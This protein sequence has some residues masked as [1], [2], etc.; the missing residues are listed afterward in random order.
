VAGRVG[1]KAANVE[2]FTANH[3]GGAWQAVPVKEVV[4]VPAEVEGRIG[5]G[6][7]GDAHL[8]A[9][10]VLIGGESELDG[11]I[12]AGEKILARDIPGSIEAAFDRDGSQQ[13]MGATQASP[14]RREH[15][16]FTRTY[17]VGRM[18][19]EAAHEALGVGEFRSGG[20]V[21]ASLMVPQGEG[22]PGEK[23]QGAAAWSAGPANYST[24]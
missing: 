9:N 11:A 6:G 22:A 5:E 19:V 10:T 14:A 8:D 17:G 18:G 15:E 21:H 23:I 1:W 20:Y 2:G 7:K 3:D 24:W 13:W 4:A 16:N 12:A